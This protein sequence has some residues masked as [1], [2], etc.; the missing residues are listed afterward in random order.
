MEERQKTQG[1]EI[2]EI[3]GDVAEVRKNSEHWARLERKVDAIDIT[4]DR[5]VDWASG[6]E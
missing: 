4:M 1:F 5:V 6:I 3:K 2:A